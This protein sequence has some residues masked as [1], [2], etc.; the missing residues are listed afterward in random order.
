[1]K[2]IV[3]FSNFHLSENR[4]SQIISEFMRKHKNFFNL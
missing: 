1:M 4:G 2:N 3:P